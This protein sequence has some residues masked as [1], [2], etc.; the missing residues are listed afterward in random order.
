MFHFLVVD[1]EPEILEVM[2][3]YLDDIYP[4][5]KIITAN[6]GSEAFEKAQGQKFDAILTDYK[7]PGLSGSELIKKIRQSDGVNKDIGCLIITG[8]MD[9]ASL[10]MSQ[11]ENTLLLSKPIDVEQLKTNLKVSMHF[12]AI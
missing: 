11:L 3:A 10:E 9:L 12:K 4:D 7:M 6:D 1:D 2:E 8:F 5:C